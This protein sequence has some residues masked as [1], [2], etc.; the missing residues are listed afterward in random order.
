[1]TRS[2]QPRNRPKERKENK[3]DQKG[4]KTQKLTNFLT[5]T[6]Q[7]RKDKNKQTNVLHLP[8]KH[9][10]QSREDFKQK[11]VCSYSQ[12][13]LDQESRVQNS[14]W[15]TKSH[16]FSQK[17]SFSLK[18]KTLELNIL[19]PVINARNS[20]IIYQ[21]RRAYLFETELNQTGS[22]TSI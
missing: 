11:R 19:K 4:W 12:T 2:S 15:L 9:S 13:F 22:G 7:N 1:L 21:I 8:P 18:T 14:W 10:S 5:E 16:N 6:Y 17:K 20:Q 3:T